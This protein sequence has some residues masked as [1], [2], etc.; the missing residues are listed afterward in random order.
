[1]ADWGPGA[2]APSQNSLC[3][4]G[5]HLHRQQLWADVPHLMPQGSPCQGLPPWWGVWGGGMSW[6]PDTAF[7]GFQT[8]LAWRATEMTQVCQALTLQSDKGLTRLHLVSLGSTI[9]P[10]W[11]GCHPEKC[12]PNAFVYLCSEAYD[13][14]ERRRTKEMAVPSSL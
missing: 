6:N 14:D 13:K 7:L 12:H 5:S 3:I 10:K 1:M 9:W 11:A 2:P 4:R 8:E